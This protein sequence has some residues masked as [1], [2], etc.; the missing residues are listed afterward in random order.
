MRS[1]SPRREAE[2]VGQGAAGEGRLAAGEAAGDQRRAA[3][4]TQLACSGGWWCRPRAS[5]EKCCAV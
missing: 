4:P 2:A 1:S 3:S 5:R